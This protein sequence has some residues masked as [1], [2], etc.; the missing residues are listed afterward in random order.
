MTTE[1]RWIEPLLAEAAACKTKMPWERGL[2][3]QAFIS[4]RDGAENTTS[5][6]RPGFEQSRASA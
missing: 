2:R 4:R 5:A 1:K 6:K 3:R